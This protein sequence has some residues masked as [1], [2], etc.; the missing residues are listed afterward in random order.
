MLIFRKIVFQFQH[1]CVS[2]TCF[3]TRDVLIVLTN[4]FPVRNNWRTIV[5][6]AI[7]SKKSSIS[8]VLQ[9][10]YP[11]PQTMAISVCCS[12]AGELV[13]AEEIVCNGFCRSSFHLK[14]VH[15][16]VATRDAVINCSQLFWMCCACTKM[17]A[18]ANFRHAISSTN[19]AVEAISAEHSKA[20]IELRQ[21]MEQNTAKINSILS[22]IP[23][24]LQ[25]RTGR[26][27]STSSNT[28][29]KRPRIDEEDTQSESNVTVGTK[30]IDPQVTIPLAESK[31][32]DN[33]FW[34]YLS[35][36][37]PKASEDEIRGLVQQNLNT[38]DT[39][40]VRKLVPKGK[41]LEELTFVS[42]KV[43]VGV[44][45][46]DLALLTS[47]WQKGIT[48]REFDFHPRPTFQFHRT[49]Q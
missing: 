22:Q 10:H 43:G 5:S 41:K 25:N 17:M 31:T 37:D 30:E 28:N 1:F 6:S 35:G 29:R 48:F 18:N 33:L 3:N 32:D 15:Q 19:N 2:Y 44:Q 13:K 39:I 21:E 12:C 16:S 14:C 34:L 36:F 4:H 40:D 26:R 11:Q 47:T 49:Q 23:S 9:L 7:T 42:F 27:G 45:L 46:K 24:A 20:L 38:T 8:S